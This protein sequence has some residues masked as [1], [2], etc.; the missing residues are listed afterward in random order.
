MIGQTL[1]PLRLKRRYRME[2][3]P[4]FLLSPEIVAVVLLD[5][6]TQ[7]AETGQRLCFGTMSQL[8]A[9]GEQPELLIINSLAGRVVVRRCWITTDSTQVVTIA[10]PT[11][12]T[13]G[14]T[15]GT[16]KQFRDMRIPGSPQTVLGFKSTAAPDANTPFWE[17]ELLANTP[18]LV[19]L[20]MIL[21][22][23]TPGDAGPG[24]EGS[25]SIMFLGNT[26]GTNLR[27]TLEWDEGT[28]E[29]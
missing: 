14:L 26:T 4:D 27:V 11:V 18:Q 16:N 24:G 25:R 12:A 17:H 5:D 9:V 2:R 20:N 3:P 8:G 28:P 1:L 6:L 22:G 13:A 19:E 15:A 23:G 7:D 10:R 29:T 21:F